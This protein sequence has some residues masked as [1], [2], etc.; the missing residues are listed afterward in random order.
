M[1]HFAVLARTDRLAEPGAVG[2]KFE[3]PR[4]GHL[5]AGYG[6]KGFVFAQ[7][8]AQ[9]EHIVVELRGCGE[10]GGGSW[11]DARGLHG[12]DWKLVV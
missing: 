4:V 3:P 11:D 2:G 9:E 7:E 6:G 12:R 10:V 5:V 8:G 1:Y